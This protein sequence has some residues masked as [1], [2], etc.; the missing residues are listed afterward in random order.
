M[1]G[2]LI[3]THPLED[4][5]QNDF[6]QEGFYS[7]KSINDK[8]KVFILNSCLCQ[9]KKWVNEVPTFQEFLNYFKDMPVLV[10]R[11]Y[12]RDFDGITFDELLQKFGVDASHY[13]VV[14]YSNSQQ[15]ANELISKAHDCWMR[16]L[17]ESICNDKTNDLEG[18]L[19]KFWDKY[20]VTQ[21][22]TL[23]LHSLFNDEIDIQAIKKEFEYYSIDLDNDTLDLINSLNGKKDRFDKEFLEIVDKIQSRLLIINN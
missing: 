8:Y 2:I 14:T 9:D 7:C 22:K 5:Y 20:Y 6:C 23:I 3:L 18:I 17:I 21:K 1:K 16:T 19:D 12:G 13:E 11:H 15:S 10:F 4:E